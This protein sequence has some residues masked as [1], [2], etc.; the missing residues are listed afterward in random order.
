MRKRS[1][2]SQEGGTLRH[3]IMGFQKSRVKRKK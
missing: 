3:I 2:N 1:E